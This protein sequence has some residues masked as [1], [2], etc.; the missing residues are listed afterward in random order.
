MALETEGIH[1]DSLIVGQGVNAVLKDAT[2]GKYYV[3]AEK[4]KIIASVLITFEWSDWRN[5]TIWWIQSLYVV[6]EWRGKSIFS[7]LF[8]FLKKEIIAS[9]D[10]CGLRLYVDQSNK[11]A[12]MIYKHLGM[13]DDHYRT[14]EWMK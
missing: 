4:E 14:F 9:D 6:P 10:I 5:A 12:Q 7:S 1:L 2:K 13:K 8:R 11:K 3:V